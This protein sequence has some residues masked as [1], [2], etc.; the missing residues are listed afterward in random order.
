MIKKGDNVTVHYRGVLTDGKEFDSSEGREP[1]QF[2]F[3]IGAMIPGFEKAVGTMKAGETK[4]VTIKAA[5]AYGP[6]RQDLVME[7]PRDRLPPGLPSR[8]GDK[9]QM[10]NSR[11]GTTEVKIIKAT[12]TAITID[13]NHEL[14]G[15]DLIFTIKLLTVK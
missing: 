3:G 11:G 2:T 14:A 6:S 9:L 5:E 12:D 7:V 15:Q 1:L 8:V 13:A 10:R 4:T